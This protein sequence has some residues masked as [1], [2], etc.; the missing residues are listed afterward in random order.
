MEFAE[1][2]PI[3]NQ[4]TAEQQARVRAAAVRRRVP[5]GTLLSGGGEECA[6]L[7]LVHSGQ[8]RAYIL[9]GEGREITLYRLFAL[10]L[11][12]FSATCVMRSLQF[13]IMVQAERDTE[14][15]VIP[16][17]AYKALLAESVP[18]ANYTNEVMAARFSEVMWL[19][20]QI[21]WKS[22]DR[23]LAAF[24]LE[25][26]SLEGKSCL[27]ITHEALANHLGTAREVVTRM[28]RYFQREGLVQLSRGRVELTDAARLAALAEK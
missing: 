27:R 9:S 7:L 13:D 11:C 6:G 19:M 21:L 24:L 10:D 2:F 8:L 15:W 26:A 28:L 20:E 3:W 18:A 22:F 14:L 12:L 4:L 5:K 17:E 25:E 16:P 23:R 1:D